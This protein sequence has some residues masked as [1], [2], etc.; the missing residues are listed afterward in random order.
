MNITIRNFI[1][2]F[3]VPVLILL[4]FL[5]PE[6]YLR[7]HTNVFM[8]DSGHFSR[9]AL[10]STFFLPLIFLSLNRWIGAITITCYT[11]F[12]LFFVKVAKQI[13][14]I[15]A[16]NVEA[17]MGTNSAEAI[18][19]V[20][21]NIP[22]CILLICIL[23]ACFCLA[24]KLCHFRPI[25]LSIS[26]S[27]VLIPWLYHWHYTAI[28]WTSSNPN[29]DSTFN[30]P[31]GRTHM[32]FETYPGVPGILIYGGYEL[33]FYKDAPSTPHT[34]QD[35]MILSMGNDK[36]KNIII[37][38]GESAT[39]YR[40]GYLNHHLQT[41][42]F[43]SQL[44]AEKKACTIEKA[45]SVAPLTNLVL[46]RILSFQ[47]V[48][49]PEKLYDRK[50]LIELASQAGYKTYWIGNQTGKGP[51]SNRYGYL[52]RYT[53]LTL[54]PDYLKISS[55]EN[56]ST[57]EIKAF[58][59]KIPVGGSDDFDLLKPLKIIL[60]QDSSEQKF[61]ILHLWGSHTGY[62]DKSD[63]IDRQALPNSDAYDRSIHHTDRLLEQI[64][65][66]ANNN[67]NQKYLLFYTSD[68][69]EDVP[70]QGHGI[71]D[72]DWKQYEIP[73]LLTWGEAETENGLKYCKR[74]N[75]M[76]APTGY[77]SQT[78]DKIFLSE[79]MGYKINPETVRLITSND[80]ILHVDGE[81]YLYPN[82]RTYWGA[83]EIVPKNTSLP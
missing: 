8:V 6:Y 60:E 63:K 16:D 68:H 45:H 69:G 51:F 32:F 21:E 42:P 28:A 25:I 35:E 67:L 41:T 19:I 11:G 57:K 34:K 20:A 46:P 33:L 56:F 13:G 26:L 7:K 38:I 59:A 76:R 3:V 72:G 48:D 1:F 82:V 61:I 80:R 36:A 18:S 24:L 5:Y 50:N 4:I 27:C 65:K 47:S 53:D 54:R 15:A 29:N 77:F 44:I 12:L 64:I 23:I 37:V 52:S 40:H 81:I 10:L 2:K 22:A 70:R 58:H 75:K 43:A 31:E 17:I 78:M 66:L 30:N 62:S 39:A 74:I 79:M 71:W 73:M 55:K 83:G 49:H 9:N 14:H